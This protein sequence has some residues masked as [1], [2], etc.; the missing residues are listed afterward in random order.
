V[1]RAGR[2]PPTPRRS[3]QR[4]LVVAIADPTTLLGRDVRAVLSERAFPTSKILL[5]H[6]AGEEGLV[7][8]DDDG[9]AY[10]APLTPDAL[11]TAD[12]AFLCGNAE[13]TSRFLAGR[14]DDGCLAIDLSGVRAGGAFAR[15]A[16]RPGD[17]P[18]PDGNLLLTFDP[19]ALVLFEALAVV[20]SI[21][22]VAGLT[23]AVDRPASELGSAALDELFRQAIALAR[24]ESVPKEILG[25]QL[26]FNA[27]FPPDSGE[28]EAR[29]AEDVARLAGRPVSMALLSVRSG[30]FHGHL[31]R[32]EFRTE[33]A[34][35]SEEAVREAF[36]KDDGFEESDA[37]SLSGPVESA[38]R[39]ETLLL[40][41]A[42]SD[43]SIRIGLAADHLR[44]AGAV[45]AVKLAEQAVRERGLLADA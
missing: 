26:A 33:G 4:G 7:T 15:P 14:P 40:Q 8:G 22:P 45:M 32:V 2:R 5:F 9:A 43:R 21:A 39:D 30:V 37:E 44:R 16:A 1:S 13:G 27:H 18:L 6:T 29:V 19:V 10:V 38:G 34:A 11:E 31:L 24:F 17:A 28:F 36:R 23:A 20:E 25:T 42:C 35:P 12:V 3:S 41:V